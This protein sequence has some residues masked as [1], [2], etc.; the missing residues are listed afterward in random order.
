LLSIPNFGMVV[1]MSDVPHLSPKSVEWIGPAYAELMGLPA[2]VRRT[3]GY[4]LH[5]AQ[6]GAKHDKVKPLKGYKG[7]GVLEV[8]EDHDGDTYRAVYTVKF[9]GTVY[10]LHCFQKK[11]KKG[12][13]TPKS[14]IDLINKR[15]QQAAAI[16]QE[17][18]KQ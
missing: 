8:V 6:G 4:A 9:A 18:E 15:L 2:G 17:K 16:H 12:I 7:A 11:A 14:T 1:E 13:S 3:V 10:V 5:M